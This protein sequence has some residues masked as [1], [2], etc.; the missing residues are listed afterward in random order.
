MQ[1][2]ILLSV[3]IIS[4]AFLGTAMIL[5]P[6]AL[7]QATTN[8]SG[9][10]QSG[11]VQC[12]T[13]PCDFPPS[14]ATTNQ[15]GTVQS[16]TVQCITAPCDYHSPPP[17][18]SSPKLNGNNDTVT[19]PK[20]GIETSGEGQ[21]SSDEKE[22]CL[23]PC[24]PGTEMC[25]QMCKPTGQQDIVNEEPQSDLQQETNF[26][27]QEEEDLSDPTTAGEST[28]N[29]GGTSESESTAGESEMSSN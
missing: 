22:P 4:G 24:P 3:L 21:D 17:L 6:L 11:T 2:L 23:S 12:I 5:T 25:I 20:S 27:P 1:K 16:G 10:V 29:D 15:S 9:T 28:T 18:S 13:A 8:Q 26:S 14:Q 19:A 7:V